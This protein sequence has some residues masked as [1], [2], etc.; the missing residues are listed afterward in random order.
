MLQSRY[1][2]CSVTKERLS[3]LTARLGCLH[4]PLH[5]LLFILGAGPA[6]KRKKKCETQSQP[7][8]AL[9]VLNELRPGLTYNTVSMSGPVHAPTFTISVEVYCK[10]FTDGL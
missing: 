10:P 6:R 5:N 8:N 1:N 2:M 7:K 3:W 4:V 9:C